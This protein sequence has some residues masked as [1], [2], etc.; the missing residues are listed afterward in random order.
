MQKSSGPIHGSSVLTHSYLTFATDVENNCHFRLGNRRSLYVFLGDRVMA[1]HWF[2]NHD[3]QLDWLRGSRQTD[4]FY[5]L[6]SELSVDDRI[7]VVGAFE[8]A[9]PSL[10]VS[11]LGYMLDYLSCKT[12]ATSSFLSP[13]VDKVPSIIITITKN[14]VLGIM[15][16]GKEFLKEADS[17]LEAQLVIQAPHAAPEDGEPIVHVFAGWHPTS[18]L[19]Q[20]CQ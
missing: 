8:V 6:K 2:A 4:L 10:G 15:K 18:L 5:N 7:D 3:V 19:A 11:F 16:K 13:D 9:R 17:S 20:R 12:L 14:L 1:D